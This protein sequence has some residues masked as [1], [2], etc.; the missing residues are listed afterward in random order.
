[1]EIENGFIPADNI[2]KEMISSG[3]SFSSAIQNQKTTTT[4]GMAARV[5]T[6]NACTDLFY[7][8]GASRGKNI[9]SEFTA[10]YVENSDYAAR[11]LQW[12][13]DIRG[14]AGER[15]LF[16]DILKELSR[17]DIELTKKI[18]EKVPEIGRFDDLLVDFYETE[19]KEYACGIIKNAIDRAYQAQNLL[20]KFDDITEEQAQNLLQQEF[21]I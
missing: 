18:I 5:S 17:Q 6:A 16:R 11:I 13:R 3:S 8:I 14:G 19:V 7:K 2:T 20:D 1:M 12:A 9:I 10:A 4:N 21:S 15:Q